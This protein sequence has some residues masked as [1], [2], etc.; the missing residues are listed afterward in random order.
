VGSVEINDSGVLSSYESNTA[1]VSGSIT[2]NTGNAR[3]Y[4][5]AGMTVFDGSGTAANPQL[6]EVMSQ[7]F[8][9]VAAGFTN[10]FTYGT[11]N[12][13]NNTYVK[14]IDQARNASGTGAE[15]LYVDTLIVPVGTTLDLGG[16]KVYAENLQAFGTVV[17]GTLAA[18][19]PDLVASGIWLGRDTASGNLVVN[20]SV[21][22]DGNDA[23]RSQWY[24]RLVIN[25]AVSG[26]L[27]W[28][29]LLSYDGR[30]GYD[31]PLAT[32]ATCQ[33]SAVIPNTQTQQSLLN[34]TVATDTA[35]SIPEYSQTVNAEQNNS[36]ARLL[37]PGKLLWHSST[38]N[39]DAVSAV[40]LHFNTP[41]DQSS[42]A[43]PD[44]LLSFTG[45]QGTLTATGFRWINELTLEVS[46]DPQSLAGHY[47]LLFGPNILDSQGNP[48]DVNQNGISGE[49]SDDRYLV[50]FTV[51]APRIVS[52]M[53]SGLF[54]GTA[55]SI[56]VTFDRPMD[57]SSFD[58]ADDI[59]TL[60]GPNGAIVIT[61]YT[62]TTP[63]ELNIQITPQNLAGTYH[64][65]LGPRILDTYGNALDQDANGTIGENPADCYSTQFTV[66]GPRITGH[67][68]SQTTIGPL[69]SARFT[70]G[71]DMDTTSFVLADDV[72]DFT[73]PGGAITPT[74]YQWLD[75]RTLELTFEPQSTFGSYT[76]M[77]GSGILDTAG[78]ALDQNRNGIPGEATDDIYT[79]CMVIGPVSHIST[80]MT[81]GP[82]VITVDRSVTVDAG[83]TLTLSPGTILKFTHSSDG[84][85]VYGVLNANG[86]E[87]NPVVFTS[88][89]DDAAG[90]DTNGD[91]TATTPVTG[92]WKGLAFFNQ[93]SAS[94][95]NGIRVLYAT[96]G[97]SVGTFNGA[98]RGYVK[99]SDSILEHNGVA[100]EA[101]SAY[102][103]MEAVNTL[104]ANNNRG[105]LAV[106]TAGVT[107]RNCTITGNNQ[108]A[109]IGHPVL[110][111][112]NCIVAYNNG[113]DIWSSP[114]DLI[115]RSNVFWGFE[116]QTITNW[117]GATKFTGN[118]NI[119]ADPLFVDRVAGNYQLAAGSP[120][121]DAALGGAA[122]S[123]DL[124]GRA[125]Y[126]DLGMPN[127][128]RGAPAYV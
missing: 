126:D 72:Q 32:G 8:G 20:W 52:S 96:T 64:L 68:P 25:D 88:I 9:N 124:L 28:S 13:A 115:I 34:V 81:W 77:L 10:N 80:D 85:N 27:I 38:I 47:Q 1:Y 31:G 120:A 44:D 110:T 35:N 61:G 93:T 58:P 24:D 7:D 67:S 100:I 19:A 99:L 45:P 103:S 98:T 108:L 30:V 63:A 41:M 92:S 66:A 123:T 36:L 107:F 54:S 128:G 40:Q 15:A 16:L 121:I 106:G 102:S 114:E 56:A 26:K 2:G 37:N 11:L 109:R 116:A 69:S 14:L 74:G 105:F 111:M 101:G 82:G 83:A 113:V 39:N 53:P 5:P 55:D 3:F 73:G 94:T 75:A 87:D 49:A 23:V 118:G 84:I 50:S 59:S 119:S 60:T 29:G 89:K 17:G 71:T 104:I 65:T 42:F 62:W 22:N 127:V 125:R 57:P 70:F 79:A 91:G 6:L 112:E 51:S 12:L 43:L 48:L 97:V 76:L 4:N 122:T 117:M 21:R 78:N 86:T 46:F 90:G 18:A 95:L 33:R